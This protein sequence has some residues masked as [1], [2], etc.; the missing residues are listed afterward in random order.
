MRWIEIA[1]LLVSFALCVYGLSGVM[2]DLFMDVKHPLRAQ[3]LLLLAS[4]ALAYLVTQFLFV[5]AL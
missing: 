4:M 1:T 3:F 5:L 2:F